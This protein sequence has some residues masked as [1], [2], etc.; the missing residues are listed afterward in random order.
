MHNNKFCSWVLSTRACYHLSCD[1]LLMTTEE[2]TMTTF[3]FFCKKEKIPKAIKFFSFYCVEE[4]RD[5]DRRCNRLNSNDKQWNIKKKKQSQKN[6]HLYARFIHLNS[7]ANEIS[8][9]AL[10]FDFVWAVTIVW[11]I[12]LLGNRATSVHVFSSAMGPFSSGSGIGSSVSS[13]SW[14]SASKCDTIKWPEW[15]ISF[16]FSCFSV[17][18]VNVRNAADVD[19]V[20]G[21]GAD[22]DVNQL[23]RSNCCDWCDTLCAIFVVCVWT[24]LWI[25]LLHSL[26]AFD[27]NLYEQKLEENEIKWR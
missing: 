14:A 8:I 3:F 24:N 25:S 19:V 16:S 9:T 10:L 13:S 23:S 18:F 15:M 11:L 17:F 4:E 26:S 7:L 1:S 27:Q 21:D 2:R 5:D 6:T 22:T 20:G 12:W